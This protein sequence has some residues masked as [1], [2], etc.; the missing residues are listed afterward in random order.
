[1]KID[2][3]IFTT[4]VE[5]SDF[6]N[7]NSRL[8][9]TKL[10][11]EPICFLFGD[12][13]KT[14]MSEEY[15]KVVEMPV[16]PDLPFLLQLTWYKFFHPITEPDTTWMIGDID[17]LPLQTYWFTEKI[18]NIS[19]DDYVHLNYGGACLQ[20][21]KGPDYWLKNATV[22]EGGCDLIGH[23]HVAKGRTFNKAL[24][25]DSNT[26]K[27]EIRFI[28]NSKKYGLGNYNTSF[29]GE[30]FYW[31]AEEHRSTELI[32]NSI[33]KNII[34]FTGI[35]YDNHGQRVDRGSFNNNDYAYDFTKLANNHYVDVHCMRPFK[36]YQS[37][38]ENLLKLSNML[39]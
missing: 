29:Y 2:K 22:I 30:K 15:G 28:V 36:A 3:V 5:Y 9:K 27:D 24:K 39:V 25:H 10:N 35:M 17:M 20:M 19:D 32:K 16:D 18:K 1:M 12:R 26:F 23:Y 33:N 7:I 21:G 37:Q 6:W 13:K 31:C 38:T 11:I 34:N 8:F 14:D 4:S